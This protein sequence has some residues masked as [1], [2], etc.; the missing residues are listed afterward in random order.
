M[1]SAASKERKFFRPFDAGEFTVAWLTFKGDAVEDPEHRLMARKDGLLSSK[2]LRGLF[3]G[4]SGYATMKCIAACPGEFVS[5]EAFICTLALCYV[6]EEFIFEKDYLYLLEYLESFDVI[7][8]FVDWVQ[9]YSTVMDYLAL[10]LPP[11]PL[12]SSPLSIRGSDDH[13]THGDPLNHSPS[14][15]LDK[16]KSGGHFASFDFIGGEDSGED[17]DELYDSDQI[18]AMEKFAGSYHEGGY[19]DTVDDTPDK[20]GGLSVN[21]DDDDRQPTS[22]APPTPLSGAG[23]DHGFGRSAGRASST[24]KRARG[25][26]KMGRNI[27]KA[28]GGG[29]SKVG[30]TILYGGKSQVHNTAHAKSGAG[31]EPDPGVGAGTASL[32]ASA[33]YAFSSESQ[34]SKNYAC[35]YLH[36]IS[37]GKWSKRVWHRRWFVLDRQNGVLSYYRYNPANLISA[38]PHGNIV[39]M[40]D[41]DDGDA[42]LPARSPQHPPPGD[43][44]SASRT[45][46]SDPNLRDSATGG[47]PSPDTGDHGG[48]DK[49]QQNLLYLCKTHPWYRGEFDLNVDN[50]SLLF[51][52]SLAKSAPTSYFFQVTTLSLQEIDS[53]R[54]VQYKLCA[55]NEGDFDMWTHA[56]ATAVNRKHTLNASHAAPVLSHQQLYRQKLLQHEHEQQLQSAALHTSTAVITPTAADAI[57]PAAP[58]SPRRSSPPPPPSP[59]KPAAAAPLPKPVLPPIITSFQPPPLQEPSHWRLDVSIEGT[60]P[61]LILGF[62]VNM[63]AMKCL[64]SEHFVG[65]FAVCIVVTAGYVLSIYNPTPKFAAA[66]L[67]STIPARQARAGGFVGPDGAYNGGDESPRAARLDAAGVECT[68]PATCCLHRPVAGSVERGD[69]SGAA[70][71]FSGPL[72]RRSSRRKFAMGSSMARTHMNESGR[73]TN[74]PHSWAPTRGETF[75]VRSLEYKKTRRKERVELPTE[76]ADDKVFIIN[77][78]LPSYAPSV[79]GDATA[80][81][82]GFSLV[83]YW[84]I[85]KAVLEELADPKSPA[86]RLYKRFINAGSDTSVTDRFKVIAQVTN[87]DECGITGMGKKLL[88]SHN[89]T[90]VLTRPQHRIYHFDGGSTEVV[91]DIH[92]FSYI[93]RRGIHLLLDKTAKL[94]ID[95]GFVLQGESEEELPEQILGCCRLDHADVQHAMV[96]PH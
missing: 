80:N 60:K 57:P 89:A 26:Q 68:D 16:Q 52:K 28:V 41:S 11:S 92:S 54:G 2:L 4:G 35:G 69:D 55:D 67:P 29:I 8:K 22:A 9:K 73:S 31:A 77:A 33:G 44:E 48:S 84:R 95:I 18:S 71:G 30:R 21:T 83:L 86:L 24:P 90:P 59:P 36:K 46:F 47:R 15:R 27:G 63:I 61:C 38:A 14:C 64:A 6:D 43:A 3:G 45:R 94:V 19:F 50:V 96:I 76:F 88:T 5:K 17:S 1:G 49:Q 25:V 34:M 7:P 82:P 87:Q 23:S 58:P 75:S 12:P 65:K 32:L 51:E 56:I 53:K 91:V 70:S 10:H 93:A 39:R 40:E 20:D 66:A 62:V 72:L 85:P 81:G 37:D 74:V 42:P 13:R 78:Q 79:W